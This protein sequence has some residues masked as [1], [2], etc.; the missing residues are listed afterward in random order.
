MAIDDLFGP[1]GGLAPTRKPLDSGLLVTNH[2]NLF[3]MLSAGLVMPPTGFGGKHYQDTLGCFPGWIPLFIDAVPRRAIDQSTTEASHLRPVLIEIELSD[4]SGEATVY[5][6][7]AIR[8]LRFPEQLDGTERVILLP[9]PLPTSR[10]R[11]VIYS[12]R[13]DK[14]ICEADAKDF[15]N[16]PIK[17][18][19]ARSN[20]ALFDKAPHIPWPPAHRPAK[21]DAALQAPLAAGGVLSML[22]HVG[23]RGEVAVDSCRRAF[24]PGESSTMPNPDP[25]LAGVPEWIEMGVLPSISA[26][27]LGEED[28]SKIR[29]ETH[30]RL[31]WGSIERLLDWRASGGIGNAENMLLDFLTESAAAL[32]SRVQSGTRQLCETLSSLTGLANATVSALF[33]RHPTPMA[34]AMILFFLRRDCADLL[35]FSHNALR[36]LDWVMAAILFGA[37]DGWQR[38]PLPLRA[39]SGLSDAVSHRM[40]QMAHRIAGTE[41]DLGDAPARVSSLRELFGD[42]SHWGRIEQSAALDL[43]RTQ[44]WDCIETRISLGRGEYSLSVSG[45]SAH[46]DMPGEP[47]LTP[48]IDIAKFFDHLAESR[49]KPSVEARVRKRLQG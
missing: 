17:D 14:R 40:A 28:P 19:K 7:E 11:S 45:G 3:Y 13:D 29:D 24:D 2:L 1:Q 20:K 10:I 12:S 25:I 27:N 4:L 46:I 37:R 8:Q 43:A 9:A 36:E 30:K 26:G 33:E 38:L 44:K 48:R 22:L 41:L 16:V 47:K 15:G 32:D 23:N 35:D 49:L 34:R 18:F 31:F 5:R 39:T 21:R 42:G 6:E